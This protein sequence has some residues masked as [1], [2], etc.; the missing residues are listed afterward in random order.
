MENSSE[1]Q[2]RFGIVGANQNQKMNQKGFA[3]IN[4]TAPSPYFEN[5]VGAQLYEDYM[6]ALTA[7][8]TNCYK[9]LDVAAKE[10]KTSDRKEISEQEYLTQLT[11]CLA[12]SLCPKTYVRQNNEKKNCVAKLAKM[13]A[14]W[15]QPFEPTKEAQFSHDLKDCLS[16]VKQCLSEFILHGSLQ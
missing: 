8:Q 7:A 1:I 4:A 16:E 2:V 5:K 14:E 11:G 12:E 3:I 15:T 6:P 13:N 9:Y 10:G